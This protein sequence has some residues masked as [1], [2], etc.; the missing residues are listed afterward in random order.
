MHNWLFP[1]HGQRFDRLGWPHR[2]S[3]RHL[4]QVW[5]RDELLQKGRVLHGRVQQGLTW[6]HCPRRIRN[7]PL[8]PRIA[9]AL[10][11]ARRQ[12][13]RTFLLPAL[14]PSRPPITLAAA[15]ELGQVND[16]PRVG[17]IDYRG[18]HCRGRMGNAECSGRQRQHDKYPD[19][20][21]D[22]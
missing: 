19:F 6:I 20:V 12:F 5:Q 4:H 11:A 15:A 21:N 9:E 13:G 2:A 7:D 17:G 22:E 1:F 3:V 10:A 18:Q 14:T 16:V 8:R